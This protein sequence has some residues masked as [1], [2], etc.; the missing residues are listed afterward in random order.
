MAVAEL[1][2]AGQDQPPTAP[3]SWIRMAELQH[4]GL[5]APRHSPEPVAPRWYSHT[6]TALSLPA[7]SASSR[8]GHQHSSRS[9][10]TPRGIVF[11]QLYI[12]RPQDRGV[13]VGAGCLGCRG[14]EGR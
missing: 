4:W 7:G 5:S 12:S 1:R 13:L 14:K 10:L 9:Y 8:A 2:Y 3:I 11:P 6:S